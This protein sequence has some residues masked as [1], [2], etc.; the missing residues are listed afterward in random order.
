MMF[1]CHGG[2][3]RDR[4]HRDTSQRSKTR[5]VLPLYLQPSQAGDWSPGVELPFQMFA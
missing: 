2:G 4:D 5:M 3:M 1:S